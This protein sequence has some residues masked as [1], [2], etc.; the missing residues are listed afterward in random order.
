MEDDIEIIIKFIELNKKSMNREERELFKELAG[1]L[2]EAMDIVNEA[3][4]N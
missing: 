1:L 3:K 4:R 2:P